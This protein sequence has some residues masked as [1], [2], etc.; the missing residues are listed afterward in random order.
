MGL[1]VD[2]KDCTA[3]GDAELEEMADLLADEPV[4]FDIGEL[5]KQRDAWVLVTQVHDGDRLHGY[6]FCTL[7]RVGG[8][9][10]VLV[11]LAA[12]K[13]TSRRS[14]V[15]KAM[16][17]DQLRRAVLAFP[18][19]DVLVACQ[20]SEPGAIEAFKSL[21]RVVPRPGYE[22]NGEDRAWGRRLSKRFDVRGE[23]KVREFRVCGDGTPA[24]VMNH[25]ALKPD[26]VGNGIAALFDTLDAA[27][28]DALITFGW[29]S[30]ENLSKLL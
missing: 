24:C 12:V 19:E 29:A 17:T 14:T 16:M 23:Y 11:G 18:D 4:R 13:R 26:S 15:L 21:D 30:R 7:E 8:D 27:N 5:S 2:T 6:G 28:G 10:A 9:P 20:M 22:A 1:S 3:L 25:S